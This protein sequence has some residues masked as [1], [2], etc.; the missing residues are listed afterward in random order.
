MI[1]AALGACAPEVGSD[2]WC[3]AM[4]EKS[5]G[6]WSVNEVTEFAKSCVFK[7]YDED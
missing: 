4:N 5:K 6:D 2:A 1:F 3:E 7:T